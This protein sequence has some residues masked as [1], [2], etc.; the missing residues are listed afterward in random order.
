[1]AIEGIFAS[2]GTYSGATGCCWK[3]RRNCGDVVDEDDG[4]D[5]LIAVGVDMDGVSL[6]RGC[7]LGIVI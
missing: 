2:S 4:C 7:L 5:D 1:M 6:L 3:F